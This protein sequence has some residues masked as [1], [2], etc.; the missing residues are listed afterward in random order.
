MLWNDD[1]LTVKGGEEIQIASGALATKQHRWV[2]DSM[3]QPYAQQLWGASPE[4][5]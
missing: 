5:G 3:G 1:Q 2:S 4:L